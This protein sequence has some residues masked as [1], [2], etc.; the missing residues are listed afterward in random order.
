[1]IHPKSFQT[2]EVGYELTGMTVFV[3]ANKLISG[4]SIN[5]SSMPIVPACGDDKPVK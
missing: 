4:H 3:G 2:S 1:M 5:E